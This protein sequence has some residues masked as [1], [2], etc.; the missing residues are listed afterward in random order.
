MHAIPPELHVI[1]KLAPDHVDVGIVETR[2]DP[3]PPNIDPLC[4]FIRSLNQLFPAYGYNSFCPGLPAP[5]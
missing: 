4:L 3:P 1:V 5:S 2:D